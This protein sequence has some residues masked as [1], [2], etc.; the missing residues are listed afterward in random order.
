MPVRSS[1]LYPIPHHRHFLSPP[2][3][4]HILLSQKKTRNR[5]EK[6][7]LLMKR[8]KIKDRM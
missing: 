7:S 8:H 4:P 2:T 1:S 3:A 6:T 5:E